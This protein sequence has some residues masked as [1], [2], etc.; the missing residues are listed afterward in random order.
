MQLLIGLA[1]SPSQYV[2]ISDFD[3]E[4]ALELQKYYLRVLEIADAP[5][6]HCIVIVIDTN[7]ARLMHTWEHWA[8]WMANNFY[9]GDGYAFVPDEVV[10]DAEDHITVRLYVDLT[11]IRWIYDDLVSYLLDWD[12]LRVI[13]KKDLQSWNYALV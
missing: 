8:L 12:A 9:I 1:V 13:R 11:G 2:L 10:T 4:A 7:K 5:P 3:P 6:L